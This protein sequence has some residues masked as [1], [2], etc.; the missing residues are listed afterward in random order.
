ML[1]LTCTVSMVFQLLE[2]AVQLSMVTRSVDRL[3]HTW[4][5]LVPVSVEETNLLFNVSCVAVVQF[6]Q[7]HQPAA[8]S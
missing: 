2:T 4:V 8:V 7:L 5:L 3:L 1:F 6:P